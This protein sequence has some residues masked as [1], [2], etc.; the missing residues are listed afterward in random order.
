LGHIEY[1]KWTKNGSTISA[2]EA[3][4]V[5]TDAVRK[6]HKKYYVPVAGSPEVYEV[7]LEE[8][9]EPGKTIYERFS[10]YSLPT[11]GS[12]VGTYK[13]YAKNKT[14]KNIS[15]EIG[16]SECIIPGPSTISYTTNLDDSKVPTGTSTAVALGVNVKQENAKDTINYEWK[17][18]SVN[19]NMSGATTV[20]GAS[21]STYT[22]S[23]IGIYPGYYQVIATPVRNRENGTPVKSNI[24]RV[25]GK[26]AVPVINSISISPAAE[27]IDTD[28]D[29]DIDNLELTVLTAQMTAFG[30]QQSDSLMYKWYGKL[31]DSGSLVEITPENAN[32]YRAD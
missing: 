21:G 6:G 26:P 27:D 11:E 32:V 9:F 10:I 28:G 2:N 13:A 5:S 7:Y 8:E 29:I 15:N 24:C 17:Y 20:E 31:A 23:D 25:T 16:S 22:I 3:Y 4:R 1:T 30:S 19:A 14:S 12:I 18:D